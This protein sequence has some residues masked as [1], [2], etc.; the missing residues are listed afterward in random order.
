MSTKPKSKF[1]FWPDRTIGKKE[2]RILREEHNEL[3]NERHSLVVALGT[4]VNLHDGINDGG[5]GITEQDWHDAR[6]LLAKVV[7]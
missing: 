4:L 1:W 2:S 7:K 6:E 5:E 3:A